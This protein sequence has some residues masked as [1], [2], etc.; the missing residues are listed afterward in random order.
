MSAGTVIATLITDHVDYRGPN[1]K[2]LV[3]ILNSDTALISELNIEAIAGRRFA[4]RSPNLRVVRTPSGRLFDKRIRSA[5]RSENRIKCESALR[6]LLF[7]G[8]AVLI[9]TDVESI[10]SFGT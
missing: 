3:D 4:N 5:T 1:T 9:Q 10:Y 8:Q 7:Y 6:V 2:S